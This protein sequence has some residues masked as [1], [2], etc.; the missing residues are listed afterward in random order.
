MRAAMSRNILLVMSAVCVLFVVACG[1]PEDPSETPPDMSTTPQP[2]MTTTPGEDM[3]TPQPDMTTPQPDMTTPQP[4]MTTPQPDMNTLD[5][6]NMNC[7]T[8]AMY[9]GQVE[10]TNPNGGGGGVFATGIGSYAADSGLAQVNAKASEAVTAMTLDAEDDLVLSGADRIQITGA[11][12]TSTSFERRTN[13]MYTGATRLTFQDQRVGI[14][15]FV[16]FEDVTVDKNGATVVPRVGSR[17]N[18]TVSKIKVFA[19]ETPQI[20]EIV[21]FEIVGEGVD[22]GVQEMTGQDIPMSMFQQLVR[23]HGTIESAGMPCG[24]SNNCFQFKHGDKTTILRIGSAANNQPQVGDC[25][26]YVGPVS[27]FPGPL[28]MNPTTQLDAVN[29]TWYRGPFR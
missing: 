22:V 3:T 4:D 17:V 16:D 28:G 11:I 18:F 23:V 9:K 2:D 29:F 13:N 7:D 27:S 1:G 25:A 5:M 12:I 21:D 14:L 26:T 24:G 6:G 20:A 19:K 15:A 10:N 8:L